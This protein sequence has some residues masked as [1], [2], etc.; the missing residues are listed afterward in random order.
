MLDQ[1]CGVPGVRCLEINSAFVRKNNDRPQAIRQLVR[2]FCLDVVD[3]PDP[4]VRLN[5][6]CQVADIAHETECEL[7]GGPDTSISLDFELFVK[8]IEPEGRSFQVREIHVDYTRWLEWRRRM[9]F[10]F[11]LSA[12]PSLSPQ[13][14][15]RTCTGL[16]DELSGVTTAIRSWPPHFCRTTKA[17]FHHLPVEGS[18][19]GQVH[20]AQTVVA[21]DDGR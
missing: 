9:R 16:A 17:G 20:S 7:F 4:C 2:E 13:T 1:F 15:P 14:R 6:F 12:P 5:Q 21:V 18:D 10:A 11:Y 8:L 3:L 19:Y